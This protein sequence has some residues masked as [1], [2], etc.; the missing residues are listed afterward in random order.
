MAS[1]AV[2]LTDIQ[3]EVSKVRALLGDLKGILD[4]LDKARSVVCMI[5]NLTGQNLLYAGSDF[6]GDGR[7]GGFATVPPPAISANSG[8]VFGAQSSSGALFTGVDGIVKYSSPD[9]MTVSF[10][11]DNPWAGSNSSSADLG[12]NFGRYVAWSVTG[13]GD[14]AAQMQF[15]VY[16]LPFEVHGEIRNHWMA[17]GGING[18]LGLPQTDETGT[19][20]GVGRFNHFNGGSIYW[21]PA[22]GAHDVRGLIRDKWA[23]MGWER[24]LGYPITDEL[25]SPDGVG[26]YSHFQN[27]VIY[28]TPTVGLPHEVHG[29]ILERWTA[30]GWETGSLGYPTSDESDDP[31]IPGGRV[32]HFQRGS[33]HWTPDGRIVVGP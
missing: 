15:V 16:E 31:G 5:F 23:S 9:G 29:A 17:T 10:D 4:Q 22:T 8:G 12:G 1:A 19:P 3:Q 2:T 30:M 33:L 28:W 25:G 13:S 7:D 18:F 21:T 11:F 24:G 14:Q 20:D 6:D 32:S 26:R 27:G